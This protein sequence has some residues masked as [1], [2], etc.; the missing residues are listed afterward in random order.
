MI[1]VR[2]L[3]KKFGKLEVL[4][5]L[6]LNVHKGSIYGLVGANGAGKTTLLKL[7]AGIYRPDQGSILVEGQQVFENYRVKEN[8]IFIPDDLFYFSQYSIRETA[9]FF[10][11]VYPTWDEDRFT[12]LTEVF[13]IDVKRRVT[14]LSKG[15][16]RQVAFWLALSVK[17]R[18]LILDEPLDGLDPMIRSRVKKLLLA[19]VAEREMSILISSHNL[20]ELEDICDY[21]GILHDGRIII[22]SELDTLKRGISKVQIAF[23]EGT[24]EE[25]LKAENILYHEKR[26]SVH[27]LIM[28]G[29]EQAI[30]T[31]VQAFNPLLLDVLP[32]TFEEIFVYEMGGVGYDIRNI[33]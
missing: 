16:K 1:E 12:E 22:E 13:G 4:K 7:I 10:R 17:P 33:L 30:K 3:V 23:S 11:Q 29:D 21:M 19:D 32:L 14:R 6:D 20:R 28:R 25:L 27:L 2:Q 18:V 26:G 5:G 15:M 31:Q 24:P 9:D 8:I